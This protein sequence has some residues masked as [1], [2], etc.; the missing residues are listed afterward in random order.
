[1]TYDA[2]YS[3]IFRDIVCDAI[4]YDRFLF[5]D[6]V[7]KQQQSHR[8]TIADAVGSDGTKV[9]AVLHFIIQSLF[10]HGNRTVIGNSEIVATFAFKTYVF[11][12]HRSGIERDL[13]HY[14]T[15]GCIFFDI[16]SRK[17]NDR[18][19]VFGID[20]GNGNALSHAS[21]S[22]FQS[23]CEPIVRIGFII[24]IRIVRDT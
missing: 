18:G 5:F 17:S 24:Q 20:H 1:M 12:R 14:G 4:L 2:S 9:I 15:D 3:D 13:S 10:C 11:D 16:A 22:V 23:H 6:I 21:V 8:Q 7:Y 19:H